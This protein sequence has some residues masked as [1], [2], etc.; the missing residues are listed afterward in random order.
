LDSVSPAYQ[1]DTEPAAAKV[2]TSV[3]REIWLWVIVPLA[4]L[5]APVWA[6]TEEMVHHWFPLLDQSGPTPASKPSDQS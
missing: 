3:S 5:F 1:N 6:E 2:A 4:A